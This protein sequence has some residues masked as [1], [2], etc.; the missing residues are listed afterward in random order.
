MQRILDTKQEGVVAAERSALGKL[1]EALVEVEASLE[2]RYTLDR[3]IRQLDELFL[4]VVA[5]EFNSGK[6]T[7]LNALL[8]GEF[9]AEGVT[10]TT[11][12]VELL[13]YG[14]AEATSSESGFLA[15]SL[16]VELLRDTLL[17]D[18]PG[19]NALDR[20][21]EAITEE[22]LPRADLVLF[23][24]SADRPF[25]ESEKRFLER[26]RRWGKKL[27]FVV[28]K[29]DILRDRSERDQVV[30]WVSEN[31]QQL[32]GVEAPVFPVAARQALAARHSDDAA[33]LQVTGLDALEAYLRETLDATERLRLKL[34]N[35]L[36]VGRE[37]LGRYRDA[38][39]E[40]LELLGEDIQALTDIEEQVS[41]YREDL[42]RQFEFRLADI[43]QVLHAFE[44]RGRQ[45][46]A[47]H[48]RLARVFDLLDK[49]RTR[50][51]F[52]RKVIA[53]LPQELDQRV[54]ELIDWLIQSELE[55]WQAASKRLEERRRHHAERIV[56]VMGDFDL[57]RQRRLDSVGRSAQ[58][59]LETYD[60]AAE[61]RRLAQSVRDAV[62]HTALVEVGA[63]GLG[64]AVTLATTTQVID[65]TGLLLA[66]TMATLGLL[67]LPARRRKA[68][69]ELEEKTL[70]LRRE[71][72]QALREQFDRE[73]EGSILRLEEATGPYTRFVRAERGRLENISVRLAGVENDLAS[74]AQRLKEL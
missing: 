67:I 59:S 49:E 44:Q 32:V 60:R 50:A 4:I 8:G 73:L 23:V 71:L 65:V 39:D 7:L 10:P 3:S 26:I 38:F 9:L 72:T 20:Q 62:T 64:T 12:Q 33:G 56:G 37:L 2:D 55:Q 43:D 22:F 15:R 61:A 74:I 18:T 25:S 13:R 52:E 21:H 53:D 27:V 51:D 41:L 36:G 57:D 28:N 14:E 1:R 68:R 30:G 34:A 70:A 46:F 69:R 42:R 54:Q 63:V 19:T 35:P 5:G 45:F 58:R 31:A 6:S 40:R 17:V 16:P 11:G 48:L 66:G 47:E 29:I 24:T